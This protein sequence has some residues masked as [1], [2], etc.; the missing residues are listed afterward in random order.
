MI[1]G[2]LRISEQQREGA[3]LPGVDLSF[4]PAVSQPAR[5]FHGPLGLLLC[6]AQTAEPAIESR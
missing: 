5:E 2:Q 1:L 6:G 3:Q 4:Q